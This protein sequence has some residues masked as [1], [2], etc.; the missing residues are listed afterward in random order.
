M[1]NQQV[2]DELGFRGTRG[3]VLVFDM[4]GFDRFDLVVNNFPKEV[5]GK[6]NMIHSEG[7]CP[8]GMRY[9]YDNFML[10]FIFKDVDSHAMWGNV[11]THKKGNKK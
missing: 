3:N 6:F 11:C 4:D 7:F 10:D 8:H 2:M 9:I 1:N 5:Q